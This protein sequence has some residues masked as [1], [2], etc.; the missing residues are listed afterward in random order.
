MGIAKST[1]SEALDGLEELGFALRQSDASDARNT[2]ILR[3]PAGTRAISDGS[4]L[5][6]VRPRELL[7]RLTC[8]ERTRAIE[9]LELIARAGERV[10]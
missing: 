2:L 7:A 5:E 8:E 6:S 3:T 10:H 1:F 4:V 9:G